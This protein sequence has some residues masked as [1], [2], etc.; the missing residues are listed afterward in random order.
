MRVV[1]VDDDAEHISL[2]RRTLSAEDIEFAAVSAPLGASSL[3]RSLAPDVV[4][5]DVYIPLLRGDRLL[6]IVR[7]SCPPKTRLVLYSACDR[8]ELR[9]RALDVGADGWISK[10]DGV[11]TLL[12]RLRALP[13][14]PSPI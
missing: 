9:Q 11:A 8:E 1:L 5:F 3:V 7:K 14:R 10:E 13:E 6:A 12:R 4:L 2:V